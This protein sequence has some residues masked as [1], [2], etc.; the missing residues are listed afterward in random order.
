MNERNTEILTRNKLASLGYMSDKDILVEEQQSKQPNIVK[1]LKSAS[2]NGDGIGKPE[3]II[4]KSGSNVLIVI[5][6]KADNKKHESSDLNT[7]KDYA[8]DG[9]LHYASYLSKG[10][11][12]I[13]IG[14]SGETENEFKVS[15]YAYNKGSNRY[16]NAEMDTLR[17][18]SDYEAY[19]LN[20]PEKKK[21]EIDSLMNFAK[22]LHDFLYAHVSLPTGK[23][24]LL[25]SGMLLS[26]QDNYFR[27]TFEGIASDKLLKKMY[28]AIQDVLSNAKIPVEKQKVLLHNFEGLTLS[29]ELSKDIKTKSFTG[30]PLRE[31]LKDVSEKVYP[32]MKSQ[33]DVDV[34]GRF[35]NEFIRYTV[36]DG[37]DGFVLTPQHITNLFAELADLTVN[38]RVLDTCTGTGGFLISAMTNMLEK[39]NND[40]KLETYIKQNNLH[41]VELD[42]D[43]Y[44]LACVNMILRG[45]GQS[46]LL[47]ANSLTD[48][49]KEELKARKCNVGL[50]NPPYSLKGEGQ[51]ELDFIDSLCDCLTEGGTAIAIVPMSCAIDTKKGTKAIKERILS[52]H[53]LEAVMSMP[54]DL[55]YPVGVVTCIMVFKANVP[56]D[57]TK[58]SWFGYWKDDGFVKTKKDGRIDLNHKYALEIKSKW[59]SMFKNRDEIVGFSVKKEVTAEDEW[60]AEAYMQTDYSKLTR[61]MFEE[62]VK[63]YAIFK[64][65]NE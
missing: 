42:P 51:S 27:S 41:G 53:T 47:E 49:V 22:E 11:E 37:K 19:I 32:I 45:D 3:F 13:A 24:M 36:G 10:Y 21:L 40:S 57:S 17:T 16:I 7:P 62:Q 52:K 26:L 43:R 39:A 6:C 54:D 1:L 59:L 65:M 18:F 20:T 5:E 48:E 58:K 15:T 12:V 60:C 4:T 28:S 2:K 64:L 61:E 31:M 44:S 25:I 50:I 38:S 8:V 30:N 29:T 33:N 23:K 63:K 9:A 14:I 35:Y 34:M 46:N 56:H 55:F